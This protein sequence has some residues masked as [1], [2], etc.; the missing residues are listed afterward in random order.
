MLCFELQTQHLLLP[1]VLMKHQGKQMVLGAGGQLLVC[2]P[3]V[4]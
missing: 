3:L 1:Q 4:L 2:W